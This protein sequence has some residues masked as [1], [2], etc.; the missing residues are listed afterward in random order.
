MD[1]RGRELVRRGTAEQAEGQRQLVTQELEDVAHS[2][3]ARR[4]EAEDRRAAGEHG[5]R[6]ERD[7]LGDVGA[8]PDAAVEIDLGASRD[9]LGYLRQRVERGWSAVELA[10]AVV[11]D[12]DR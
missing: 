4:R 1:V 2:L 10:A 11:R 8:A 9:R 5:A 7:R 6:A 12:D 3:L